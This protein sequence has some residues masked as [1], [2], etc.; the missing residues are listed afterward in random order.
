MTA[1]RSVQ[2]LLTGSTFFAGLPER[3]L[4]ELGSC[5]RL[6]HLDAGTTLFRAG[7]PATTFWILREGRVAVE[8]E[9]PGRG[10]LVIS[11]RR[12]GDAVGWS[13][14]FPPY[15]WH[16]DAVATEPTRVIELDG[17]CLR[18]KCEADHE[19]GFHLMRRFAQI[20]VED[21]QATRLQLL[22]VYGHAGAT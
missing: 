22:D 6:G 4:A 7:E 14:L 15:R 10:A 3:M 17:A 11:T 13:W 21:L 18:T 12:S 2:E 16:F 5:G 20:A 9:S 1:V 19:L 8:I